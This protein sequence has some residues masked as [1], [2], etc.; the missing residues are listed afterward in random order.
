MANKLFLASILLINF[1][2]ILLTSLRYRYLLGFVDRKIS[3]KSAFLIISVA[4]FINY[5][6]PFKVGLLMGSPF[7]AKLREKISIQHSS[8]VLFFEQF[9]DII[10]QLIFI[11]IIFFFTRRN[12]IKENI[13]LQISLLSLIILIL[14][15]L[16]FKH[17]LLLK[18][19]LRF[20]SVL[21][22]RIK[23]VFKKSGLKR[24]NAEIILKDLKSL[25]V[26]RKFIFLYA[27][28]TLSIFLFIPLSLYILSK[29]FYFN[30]TY[31]QSLSV[32][33]ISFILGKLSGLPGGLGVRDAAIGVLLVNLGISTIDSIRLVFYL[34]I[35]GFFPA[36][37]AG[38]LYL[39]Y[40]GKGRL[41][42]FLSEIKGNSDKTPK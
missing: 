22:R 16:I 31:F 37:P 38:F 27:L 23:I 35:F 3:R 7:A 20:F 2:S 42:G 30:L 4:S 5:L 29:A 26:E 8:V 28:R 10:W 9:F 40:V 33:W 1:I 34:R 25:F 14:F 17:N 41:S 32:F 19:S 12:V 15:F 21:P 36:L 13:Y 18:I 24:E 39:L 11:F 6:V